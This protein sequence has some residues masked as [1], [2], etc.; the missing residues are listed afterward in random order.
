[1]PGVLAIVLALLAALLGGSLSCGQ[2]QPLSVESVGTLTLTLDWSGA[3]VQRMELRLQRESDEHITTH[4]VR[5]AQLANEQVVLEL[6]LASGTW[7]LQATAHLEDDTQLSADQQVVVLQGQAHRVT[8]TLLPRS[9]HG[10]GRLGVGARICPEAALASLRWALDEPA[11]GALELAIQADLVPDSRPRQVVATVRW[12]DR[13]LLVDLLPQEPGSWTYVGAAAVESPEMAYEVDVELVGLLDCLVEAPAPDLRALATGVGTTCQV[14][15]DGTFRCWG[16]NDEGELSPPE[17]LRVTAVAPGLRYMCGLRLEDNHPICWGVNDMGQTDS[18][19]QPLTAIAS[20]WALSCGIRAD[21]TLSCWGQCGEGQCRPPA[22]TFVE[23]GVGGGHACAR[24]VDGTVTCWGLDRFGADADPAGTFSTL[25]VGWYHNCGLRDDGTAHCWGRDANGEAQPPEG[26]Y[27]AVVAGSSVSCGLRPNGS[28]LCWGALHNWPPGG[29]VPDAEE[30]FSELSMEA[31]HVCGLRE[32]GSLRCWGVGPRGETVVASDLPFVDVTTYHGKVCG[33]RADGTLDC[34]RDNVA[35][36]GD[37]PGDEFLV[38]SLDTY[39]HATCG[40]RPDGT[41]ECWLE[42]DD[43]WE[44]GITP[45]GSFSQV[46]VARQFVC[47]IPSEGPPVCWGDVAAP[48]AQPPAGEILQRLSVHQALGCGLRADDTAVCWGWFDDALDAPPDALLDVGA[49]AYF[50]CGRRLDTTLTCWGQ[51]H[52]GAATPPEGGF[53]ELAVGER[54]SCA[55]AADGGVTCWGWDASGQSS[56][57]PGVA[58]TRI[59]VGYVDSCG[60]RAD[61]AIECWGGFPAIVY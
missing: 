56:G 57:V 20:G 24:R 45:A 25:D 41:V 12:S 60:V 14:Y 47:A 36:V 37:N 19:A 17:G 13:E 33:Q 32:D 42:I 16:R 30:R 44:Q 27:A 48:A 31:D 53:D 54:H 29:A 10:S 35:Q 52:N 39:S 18:P 26:S 15:D 23:V 61:G 3:A 34:W 55:R 58:F 28:V 5:E 6:H 11:P 4:V 50:A 59:D 43:Q 40:L 8:L 9:D 49:G 38:G 1:V 22:G 2:V 7:D 46:A 21:G 51:D